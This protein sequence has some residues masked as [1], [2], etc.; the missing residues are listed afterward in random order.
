[1]IIRDNAGQKTKTA[2]SQTANSQQQNS[3]QPTANS[4][5]QNKQTN[6][7]SN[8]PKKSSSQ[9]E[10]TYKYKLRNNHFIDI[11]EGG[12]IDI[13]I[14][15]IYDDDKERVEI[16]KLFLEKNPQA[17]IEKHVKIAINY[18]RYE[19]LKILLNEPYN[20]KINKD[21]YIEIIFN[22]KSHSKRELL[23]T[24]SQSK[25]LYRFYFKKYNQTIEEYHFTIFKVPNYQS[26]NVFD[27][28]LEYVKLGF[29]DNIN[30]VIQC[31]NVF[32][33]DNQV[34][35]NKSFNK[36][37]EIIKF[38]RNYI[39]NNFNDNSSYNKLIETLS[40]YNDHGLTILYLPTKWNYQLKFFTLDQFKNE[41]L[42]ISDK[43]VIKWLKSI[44][45]RKNKAFSSVLSEYYK[46]RRNNLIE[47]SCNQIAQYAI[48]KVR[49]CF[50]LIKWSIIV[51]QNPIFNIIN[52]LGFQNFNILI[53]SGQDD[54][55]NNNN[56]NL[57]YYLFKLIHGYNNYYEKL[58]FLIKSSI[59]RIFKTNG[60]NSNILQTFNFSFKDI[61]KDYPLCVFESFVNFY[62]N[63][64]IE[65]ACMFLNSGIDFIYHQDS[66][67]Y[68]WNKN[69]DKVTNIY[70]KTS[71]FG[72]NRFNIINKIKS[73][74][75]L[76]F[77][78]YWLNQVKIP[79]T[80]QINKLIV[81]HL[82]K[83]LIQTQDDFSSFSSNSNLEPKLFDFEFIYNE[84]FERL[85]QILVSRA[86]NNPCNNIVNSHLSFFLVI[87]RIDLF[88]NYFKTIREFNIYFKFKKYQELIKVIQ[89]QQISGNSIES[90][91]TFISEYKIINP[92]ISEQSISS[93]LLKESLILNTKKEIINFIIENYQPHRIPLPFLTYN[94]PLVQR[95]L[96]E[97]PKLLEFNVHHKNND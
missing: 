94:N 28:L 79:F 95:F 46:K 65:G 83:N 76:N 25:S 54:N 66:F 4:Q 37:F 88:F 15:C 91:K 9:G 35:I 44:E 78:N 16:F 29:D 27:E 3:Q 67:I 68:L 23:T 77:I 69:V 5:Q 7:N 85:I 19:V 45:K 48:K 50:D 60:T 11:N 20:F 84:S 12:E 75:V 6:N 18:K 1:M 24:E 72:F 32:I 31:I 49:N 39:F 82:F 53:E 17:I 30:R 33:N 81:N 2:N 38:I 13:L 41:K 59:K 63:F 47:F 61:L 8:T 70:K 42:V 96:K 26:S 14:S 71:G 10:T 22:Y 93:K 89:H 86:K 74:Q 36:F 90:L 55:N 43:Q 64:E 97:Y 56:K 34:Q 57:N 21:C 92:S 62:K 80:S 58:Q 40:I 52:E 73:E 51:K 87:R